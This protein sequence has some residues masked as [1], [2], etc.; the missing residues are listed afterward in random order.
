MAS[1]R[2]P[3]VVSLACHDLRTPLAT[4][5]GFARTLTR[6]GELD[7]RSARFV[8]MIEAA[9]EQMT[10]LLDQLG[11]L[12]RIE[13][14]RY[15][16]VLIEADTLDLATSE[17]ERVE[18]TGEGAAVETDEP[19]VRRAL[20]ALAVAA[21]RHGGVEGVTWTVRGREL[22]LTPVA[23]GAGPVVLG[24]EPRDLGA[25]VGRRVIEHFGGS[26]ALDGERLLVRL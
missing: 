9:A 3:R 23:D 8:E 19:A 12:A 22:E 1:E 13:G 26:V 16:P 7:E 6:A 24:D 15:D 2:F 11:V 10:D 20:T 4:V 18:A 25:L 5:Y 14:G 21:V 17:D